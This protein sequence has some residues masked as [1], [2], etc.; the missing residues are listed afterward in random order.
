LPGD[1]P[2][3]HQVGYGKPSVAAGFK[4]GNRANPHARPRQLQS[5]AMPRGAPALGADVKRRR[6]SKRGLIDRSAGADLAATEVLFE[7]MR[8]GDPRATAEPAQTG[9]L[10]DDALALLK[11]RLDR[12]ARGVMPDTAEGG[13]SSRNPSNPANPLDLPKQNQG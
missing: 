10:G 3:E 7:M 12:L 2:K 8:R 9:P 11:D 4:Q 5:V 13:A 1:E 6:L